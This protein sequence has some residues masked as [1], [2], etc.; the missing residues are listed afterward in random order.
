MTQQE[1]QPPT[2]LETVLALLE[3]RFPWLGK[4]EDEEVS[5]ADTIDQLS[6][7]HENLAE[8]LAQSR[9]PCVHENV[10]WDPVEIDYNSDGTAVVSQ[11]GPCNHCGSLR[12]INYE[13]GDPK[14][15]G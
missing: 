2:F 8:Q 12:T 5:G 13:P 4:S 6:D 7:L 3:E 1:S 11:T 9:S 10:A 15:V 14:V